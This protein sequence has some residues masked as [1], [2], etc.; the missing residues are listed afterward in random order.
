MINEQVRAYL[1][2]QP[3]KTRK[4]LR[5]IRDA[6]RAAVPA[7]AESFSY[8]IPGFKLAGKPLIWYAGWKEHASM[9]PITAGVRKDCAKELKRFE[10]S[11]GT[12]KFA[13]DA[14]VPVTLVKKFARIRASE[15]VAKE[16]KKK[17]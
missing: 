17:V 8:G 11:K 12:L 4:S 9:Y 10:T 2:A 6:V 7:A 15:I 16:K 5:T 3:A 1:A 14:P 13:L